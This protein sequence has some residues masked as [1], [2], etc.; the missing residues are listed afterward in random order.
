MFV[1]IHQQYHRKTYYVKNIGAIAGERG[2][3]GDPGLPGV[4]GATGLFRIGS[5]TCC[6]TLINL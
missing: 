1:D 5:F 3:N 6:F 4:P 2:Y